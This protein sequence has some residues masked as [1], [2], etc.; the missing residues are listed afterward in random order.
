M[1]ATQSLRYPS[2][3]TIHSLPASAEN[4]H[5]LTPSDAV[6]C[7]RNN[8]VLSG[9]ISSWWDWSLNSRV[10]ICRHMASITQD[11]SKIVSSLV[12]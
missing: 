10:K 2:A 12:Q 6:C 4:D 8:A 11:F 7:S 3:V 5:K 1:E 9:E